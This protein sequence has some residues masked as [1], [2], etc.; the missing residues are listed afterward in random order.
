MTNLQQR[1]LEYTVG[2]R[3]ALQQVVLEKLGKIMKL[4]H[5]LT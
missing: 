2:E 5:Y 3:H 4:D 1:S